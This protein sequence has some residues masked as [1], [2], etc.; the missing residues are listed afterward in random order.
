MEITKV[1]PCRGDVF[2]E[3]ID[4]VPDVTKAGFG[5]NGGI[6]EINKKNPFR[7]K[8]AALGAPALT[9]MGL[10]V[11]NSIKVGDTVCLSMLNTTVCEQVANGT[12]MMLN[13]KRYIRA[14]LEDLIKVNGE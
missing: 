13:G 2:L 10:E 9:P 8:V 14:I 1:Q 5:T 4:E 11:R 6:K 12:W 7:F 3:E